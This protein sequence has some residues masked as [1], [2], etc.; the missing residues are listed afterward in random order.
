MFALIL[1]PLALAIAISGLFDAE[2]ERIAEENGL[3]DF[4]PN[5]PS[6]FDGSEVEFGTN[7][8]DTLTGTNGED[9]LFALGQA[10]LVNA[11]SGD[12]LVEAG[13]NN[14]TVFGGAGDDIIGGGTE[15]DLLNGQ[16][17]DDALL[18]NGGDD[19][20]LGRAGDDLLIGGGGQD[21]LNGGPGDD[22]LI[23]GN[24]VLD[25]KG[26]QDI[27]AT[28]LAVVRNTSEEDLAA[29]DF[30][31]LRAEGALNGVD[32]SFLEEPPEPTQGGDLR[33]GD[34][35]DLLI[36]AGGD[37]AQ[38]G[39]GE[40]LFVLNENMVDENTVRIVDYTATDDV[41]AVQY[42]GEDA[43]VLDTRDR[44][45]DAIILIGED[46]L[47]L[48]EGGAGILPTDIRLIQDVRIN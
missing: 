3:N 19:L 38:G 48:V 32:V 40:D 36:L 35:D 47:A 7:T 11:L 12:D 46:I 1:I 24:V 15:F 28:A 5:E 8:P 34:G 30:E 45:D 4:D 29:V 33:G 14:D 17:G 27:S 21:S 39:D 25:E 16:A 22:V 44:G 18:G 31:A 37:T 10:D 43:P 9:A 41:I 26:E 13:S 20:L 23:S 2:V 6:I 42:A